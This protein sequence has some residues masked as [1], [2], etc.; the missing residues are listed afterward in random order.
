MTE[1]E[2]ERKAHRRAVTSRPRPLAGAGERG[3]KPRLGLQPL[4]LDIKPVQ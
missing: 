4:F 3:I 1:G 2:T